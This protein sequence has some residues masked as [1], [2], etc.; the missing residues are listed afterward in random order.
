LGAAAGY[1][2]SN[3]QQLLADSLKH[4]AETLGNF[5]ALISPDAIVSFDISTLDKFVKQ[6]STDPDIKFSVILNNEGKALTTYLP[7]PLTL[8]QVNQWISHTANAGQKHRVST[9]HFPIHHYQ[10]KLGEV[11]IGFDTQ[12]LQQ[13]MRQSLTKQFVIYIAIILFLSLIIFHI[14]RYSVMQP[15]RKLR[16]GASRVAQGQFNH[17]IEIYSG[18][19]LGELA[20]CFNN[21]LQEISADRKKLLE[22]NMRLEDEVALRKQAT[23]ELSKLS[24]AVEQSPAS[25]VITDLEGNI[26]YVNPKF[27]EVTGY[28]SAEI[29]GKKPNLLKGGNAPKSFY[30]TM[31]NTLVSG[32]IW[33][34]EFENRRKNGETYW[35]SATIAPIKNASGTVTHYLAVKEDITERKEFEKRLY[36]QA[37]H[38]ALTGLPNRNLVYDRL[39][40]LIEQTKRNGGWVAVIYI[41]LDNFKMVNDTLGHAAGDKLL[42]AVAQRLR[43]ILRTQDTLGRLGGDEFLAL[44]NGTDE[45]ISHINQIASKLVKSLESDFEINDKLFVVTSSIGIA[46]HPNDGDNPEALIRDADLAMYHAKKRGRNNFYFY[47]AAI[48]RLSMEDMELKSN[49]QRAITRN[50]FY[51]VFQPMIRLIDNAIIGAEVLLR[52]ESREQGN[53]PPI[54]FIPIAE[55]SGLIGNIAEWTFTDVL[56]KARHW[57]IPADEEFTLSFNISPRHF[58]HEGFSS[59]IA[60]M[61]VRAREQGIRLALEITEGLL[62]D[63]QPVVIERMY[64][65]QQ[66]GI[67]IAIDDFGTG[68]SSLSYLKHYPIN[69]LKIDQTFIDGIPGDKNDCM[70]TETIALM[71]R[72]LG[73][74]LVA[75]GI[76]T[77]DQAEFLRKLGVEYGQGYLFAKPMKD[78][79][80]VSFIHKLPG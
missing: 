78:H 30:R 27:T 44:V 35:E 71:G 48:S 14:F 75:E 56:D 43:S 50:E 49:L 32:D 64:E 60:S 33:E 7:E 4:K 6:L 23:D 37:T 63:N 46:L 65:L 15:V 72:K 55:E 36:E 39:S 66:A 45:D 57:K 2:T 17:K 22:T 79:D 68:Y 77:A 8:Q 20:L 69:Q 54:R 21:M 67:A 31:W 74:R 18:D 9:L 51:P 3:Q 62:L 61:A 53:I 76:E 59:F 41:D 24:R 42:I 1:F 70:L 5:V 73:Y 38:D 34:G 12:Q 25:V 80:F 40:Q 16:E 29:L 58:H 26:E 19:E 10:D 28:T 47:N 52:W 13:L 11:V